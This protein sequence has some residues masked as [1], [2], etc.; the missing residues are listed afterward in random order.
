M[1]TL[2][3][4]ICNAFNWVSESVMSVSKRPG[5]IADHP[6]TVMCVFLEE[7]MFYILEEY[8]K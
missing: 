1:A 3:A 8:M 6:K 7:E 5:E 2:G 4:A